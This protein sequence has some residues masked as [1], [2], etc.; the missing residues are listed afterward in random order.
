MG[1]V[2]PIGGRASTSARGRGCAVTI[3]PETNLRD[4]SQFRRDTS[5]ALAVL[6]TERKPISLMIM[7]V[8]YRGL[9]Q[10]VPMQEDLRGFVEG[11][12]AVLGPE[13]LLARIGPN[14]FG[15]VLPESGADSSN[16]LR[17]RIEETA[18]A[19]GGSDAGSPLAAWVGTASCSDSSCQPGQLFATAR[20]DLRPSSAV[21]QLAA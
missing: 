19:E 10:E 2:I 8:E 11:L 3:D 1:Q 9:P 12:R 20:A 15:V 21:E 16:M 17:R 7:Y 14:S 4:A 13:G 6:S 5:H 18:M